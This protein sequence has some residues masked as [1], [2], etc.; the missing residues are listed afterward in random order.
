[1]PITQR[2]IKPKFFAQRG[3]AMLGIIAAVGV[4]ATAMVVTSLSA[5]AVRN[6]QGRKTSSA[7]ALA[8][9]ALIASA[10]SSPSHPGSLPCP[11]TNDDGQSDPISGACT[12]SI[13]RLPWQTLGLPDLRD[14]AGERLW[15]ALSENFQDIAANRIN[16][17][18][19]GQLQM[20]EGE[21]YT[22]GVVAIVFAPGRTI[23]NQR[24]D[25]QYVNN[26]E[27]YLE[28]YANEN[29][30][31]TLRA[32]DNS[33]NDQLALITPADI[34]SLVGRR[35][36]KEVQN[37]LQTY[38]TAMSGRLPWYAPAC[39]GSVTVSCPTVNP[40][41]EQPSPAAAL[42][43]AGTIGYLPTDD[44]NFNSAIPSWF[45]A[46]N[47]NS[48]MSYRVDSDCAAGLQACGTAFDG[49]TISESNRVLIGFS[50]GTANAGTKA[51][52]GFA[53][54]NT[55]YSNYQTTVLNVAVQ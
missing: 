20:H 33:Y 11:D 22:T 10:A 37:A 7:L 50:G 8:R 51:V 39:T 45:S 38:Y 13:G 24:R 49:Y 21:S 17:N 34:F 1:M 40:L 52:L 15:Y 23:G 42:P 3:Y 47:W 41:P 27:G 26:M 16:T 19:Y 54:V 5:T 48:V 14:A 43:A 29:R 35:V 30:T 25:A 31:A 4:A 32:Q 46:N 28:S 12:A 2:N 6:E 55:M 36:A 18:V 44:N 9:Q 53:G